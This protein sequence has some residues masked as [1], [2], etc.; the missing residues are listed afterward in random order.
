[1]KLTKRSIQTLAEMICG[2]S[3]GMGG[4]AWDNFPYRSSTYLT[5]FFEASGFDY[6]HDGSTRKNWVVDRLNELNG[7][8]APQP[9]LP[10]PEITRIIQELLDYAD[11]KQNEIDPDGA[12]ADVN[13]T[14]ARDGL[15]AFYDENK[16]CYIRSTGTQV[17]SVP[18]DSARKWTPQEVERRAD[19][20][21][22]LDKMSEDQI[23][24]EFLQPL[25]A[26]LGFSRISIS[27]HSD[28]A[29]EFG[30]D[31]WMKFQL[32]TTH[33]LYFAAQVKKGKLDS[34]GK[35]GNTNISEVLNQIRMVL[36][37]PIWDPETN[38]R[39]LVD[40]VFI[41]SAGQ[42]TKQ[43]KT[44]LGQ[45]LDIDSRRQVIFLDRDDILNLTVGMDFIFDQENVNKGKE[46]KGP[47]DLPF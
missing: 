36:D 46:F 4:F 1:M 29:L 22:H 44:W 43:A 3:G 28:K 47:N 15:S 35:S 11:L 17:T 40:H 16:K 13:L 45:R 9:Q 5:E 6:S 42:I 27:G 41:I 37:Y 10:S 26:Q 24:E 14:L 31:L 34:A 23:I 39:V 7:L 33:Y 19:L 32:P 20:S 38:K 2:A 12:L 8:P 25:F 21:R 18:Q 30:N